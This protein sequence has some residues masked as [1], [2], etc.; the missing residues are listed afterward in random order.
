MMR[1]K[2]LYGWIVSAEIA[3]LLSN[4]SEVQKK[5]SLLLYYNQKQLQI[6]E[7]LSETFG[8]LHLS[9]KTSLVKQNVQYRSIVDSVYQLTI[10]SLN[11]VKR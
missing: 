1:E 2:C 5:R 4:F 6:F 10:Y 9:C 3:E 7:K 8:K 11:P